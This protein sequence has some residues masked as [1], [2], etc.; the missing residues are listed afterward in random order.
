MPK[1]FDLLSD[2]TD[3]E[4]LK[5]LQKKTSPKP[6][7][8]RHREKE[9]ES[10]QLKKTD[11]KKPAFYIPDFIAIDLETTGL[12]PNVDSIIEIGAIKFVK[13]K[14]TDK[15]VS[16][17]NPHKPIP[18][19]IIELTGISDETVVDA[20][21]FS[22]IM[23]SLLEFIG[24]SYLC[25]HQVEFDYNFLNAE[26]KRAGREKIGNLLLDTAVLS[27]LMLLG[28]P[29]YSLS[30]VCKHLN[31]SQDKVHRA[32]DDALACGRIAGILI[33]KLGDIPV[34]T[35]KIL[36]KFAPPSM[37]KTILIK[38]VDKISNI[39][40]LKPEFLLTKQS[41]KL[42][43]PEEPATVKKTFV[44]QCFA[45][46][47]KLSLLMDGYSHRPF[48]VQMALDIVKALN[49]QSFLIAE[50]GTGTGKSM[51]Y[52]LPASQ[53]AFMNNC[54]VLV[55][56][57]TKNL[58]DQLVSKDLPVVGKIIGSTFKYAVLKGRS[59][60]L[61]LYRWNRFLSG[62]LGNI[63]KRE[64]MGILPLIKWAEETKTGDI[65]EQNQF[66]KR[67]YARIW[68]IIS[69]DLHGCSGRHCPLFNSC[70]L[71][72]ARHK[73]LSSHLVV[74]NHAL[75]FSDICAE[76]S[77]LGKT[78]TIIFD[79][80]HHLESCGHR[81]LRVELDT[82]RINRYIDSASNLLKILE[83]DKRITVKIEII[84][85]YK[86]IL[87]RVRKNA[88]QFLSDVTDWAISELSEKEGSENTKNYVFAYR[89]N[90]LCG[91]SSLAGFEIIIKEMQD[92]LLLFH[93]LDCEGNIENRKVSSEVSL[94]SEKTSQLKAD[95]SYLTNAATDDHVFWVEGDRKKNW[96]KL[97]GVILDIGELLST[98]W[99]DT[100][101]AIIFTSATMSVS[102]SIDYFK[103]KV[104][105]TGKLEERTC[106][107]AFSSPFISEQM[108]RC[109][110]NSSLLP[111]SKGYN[112]YV[113]DVVLRLL[114]TF[115]KNILVL[116]TAN[117]MLYG[118]HDIL[119][120]SS[121]FPDG[122]IF[123]TQGIS[124]S[125]SALLDKFKGSKKSV[126]LGTNSF[127]EGIDAPGTACEIVVIP[128]LP[129]PVPT[130]PLTQALAARVEER[131]GDSFFGFS[132]PEAVIKFRQGAGR[133]IRSG[134]DRGAF[135][136]LDGRIVNKNYGKVFTRS[137]E[138][139]FV[140][141]AD[142]D[143]MI[144]K[145]VAFFNNSQK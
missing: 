89:D 100:R 78:G 85:N 132:V 138:E 58:Q 134:N 133:L 20:P 65:E 130:H 36:G 52:L 80:A 101:G 21:S 40:V 14:T 73:A 25:G 23:G 128:R 54:R 43:F 74:I 72:Q 50:A 79:E 12:D 30:N 136:V 131:F 13:G 77:F 33:P 111:D 71:Q 62:E 66:N 63:S 7:K 75:F 123:F 117:S 143:D 17:V 2:R 16:L 59:N 88:A 9:N 32:F 107:K 10:I 81:Y 99:E 103:R 22:E 141:S 61:C 139:G 121:R 108:F 127:W 98:I 60:Y 96:V 6:Y 92:A 87:K 45:E 113:A 104:G 24:Q 38:S 112:E 106:F 49:D 83:N 11:R 53:W 102:E 94:C 68:S 84:K 76:S 48:Q 31:V 95:L 18:P 91:M 105:L 86:N 124:G 1:L 41:R 8:N 42:S 46:K 114:N 39:P 34:K 140:K 93:E 44:E 26:I 119:K 109:A 55:S 57:H 118:V 67:W 90:P 135:I 129:F 51:A 122:G 116:F 5:Q 115:D 144:E 120:N 125:R 145:V 29:G 97:C 142:V 69:A 82:N 126:L 37:L 4:A 28:M 56:T 35:R 137:L 19:N 3:K 70:F 27:R 110:V 15:Y 47:G 64:R